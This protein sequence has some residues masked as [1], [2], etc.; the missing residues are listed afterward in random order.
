MTIVMT[1]YTRWRGRTG[2]KLLFQHICLTCKY[3][4]WTRRWKMRL[5]SARAEGR[6]SPLTVTPVHTTLC[7]QAQTLIQE[8]GVQWT[9]CWVKHLIFLTHLPF[10]IGVRYWLGIRAQWT[11][12]PCDWW[13]VSDEHS[14]SGHKHMGYAFKLAEQFWLELLSES[15]T[16]PTKIS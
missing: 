1:S 3:R 15:P 6:I 4:H 8:E 12:E 5:T 7:Q 14:M 9:I 16:E 13:H 11:R 2:R 10:A